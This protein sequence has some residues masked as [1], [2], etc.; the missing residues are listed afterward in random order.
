M[1]DATIS[2]YDVMG[3]K[4]LSVNNVNGRTFHLDVS[5]IPE[6][7]YWLSVND[8]EGNSYSK[9]IIVLH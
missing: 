6:G 5:D 7:I 3:D 9:K 8:A 2:L 4:I 1:H